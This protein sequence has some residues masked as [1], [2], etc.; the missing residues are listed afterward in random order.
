ML[1]WFSSGWCHHG[2][3]SPPLVSRP[4]LRLVENSLHIAERWRQGL[5]CWAVLHC[6]SLPIGTSK[7]DF[8][9]FRRSTAVECRFPESYRGEW[10]VVE[11][12]GI[13]DVILGAGYISF[14]NLGS[15][16]CKSKHYEREHYKMMSVFKNGWW[17]LTCHFLLF[18]PLD[19]AV[20]GVHP[21]NS[22]WNHFEWSILSS[23]ARFSCIQFR[24]SGEAL[25]YRLC[26]WMHS[27]WP[28][29]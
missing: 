15:F 6:L 10:R 16:I 20:C 13:E 24:K 14:S 5:W 26:E 29:E 1:H 7:L 3:F 19:I 28:V 18:H 23:Y 12:D 9:D 11:N 2:C 4:F 8:A 22:A 17:V 25:Q 21:M 27:N